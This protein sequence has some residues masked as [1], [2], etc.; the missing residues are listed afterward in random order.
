[1]SS[2]SGAAAGA[3]QTAPRQ[4]RFCPAPAS[5]LRTRQSEWHFLPIGRLSSA[6]RPENTHSWAIPFSVLLAV[7]LGVMGA[8]GAVTLLGLPNDVY[9]QVA[10]LTTVGLSAKNAILIVEFAKDLQAQ[11]K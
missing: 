1:M 3:Q 11:G 4:T 10:L 8:L 7:P 6:M 9:F 5:P 2:E